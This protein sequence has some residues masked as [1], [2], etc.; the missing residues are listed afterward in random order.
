MITGAATAVT[1][2]VDRFSSGPLQA[3]TPV[4]SFSDFQEKFGVVRN[5]NEATYGVRQF[6]L[7]GGTPGVDPARR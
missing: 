6:F 1:A 2:F 5:W 7:N 3:A 4:T